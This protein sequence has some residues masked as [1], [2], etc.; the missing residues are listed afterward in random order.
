MSEKSKPDKKLIPIN[1]SNL[2]T[3]LVKK[4]KLNILPIKRTSKP[5]PN[6]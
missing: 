1:I 4:S 5:L 3:H 2:P 6:S